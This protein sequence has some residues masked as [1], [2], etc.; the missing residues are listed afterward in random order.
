[1]TYIN[2]VYL[3]GPDITSAMQVNYLS[4]HYPF[5]GG[6]EK[7]VGARGEVGRR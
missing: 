4:L 5:G 2:G 3:V 7:G 1:M 6:K